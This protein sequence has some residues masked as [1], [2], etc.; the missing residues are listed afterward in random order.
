MIHSFPPISEANARVLILGS[1][2]GIR[3]LD[4]VEYYAHPAN[5]FWPIMAD[6]LGFKLELPYNSRINL[7]L[8]SGIALWD[9]LASCER[10]GS[11][12]SAIRTSTIVANDIPG[13]LLQ[14]PDIR[15]IFLNGSRAWN[16]FKRRIEPL[17]RSRMPAVSLY[18]MPSTSPAMATMSFK[19]KKESWL[20]LRD[21]LQNG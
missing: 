7:L 10:K 18:K 8:E 17:I 20:L 12:D 16:E 3:S 2:P 9:V 11:L 1:M 15:W 21:K 19:Q 13:L 6:I 5:V 14:C 4:E